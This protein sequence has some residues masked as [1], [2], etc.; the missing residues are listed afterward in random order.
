MK[1]RSPAP[2]RVQPARRRCARAGRRMPAFT[3]SA[4]RRIW[5]S[6]R[7]GSPTRSATRATRS[8]R[9]YLISVLTRPARRARIST[10]GSRRSPATHSIQHRRPSRSARARAGCGPGAC[11]V[12][13]D[14]RRCTMPPRRSSANT[15]SRRS[16]RPNQAKSPERP[17][18]G[19]TPPALARYPRSRLWRVPSSQPGPL[20]VGSLKLVGRGEVDVRMKSVG[21]LWSPATAACAADF[22]PAAR[23]LSPQRSITRPHC[24][25]MPPFHSEGKARLPHGQAARPGLGAS[26]SLASFPSLSRREGRGRAQVARKRRSPGFQRRMIRRIATVGGLT[27]ALTPL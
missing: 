14:V 12:P 20:D 8:S 17:S 7:T 27:L 1:A 21:P 10:R 26:H 24:F 18:T 11:S 25:A 15:T 2:S 3:R 22:A 13:L 6:P 23:P 16:A 4:R 19:S 5:I 9:P